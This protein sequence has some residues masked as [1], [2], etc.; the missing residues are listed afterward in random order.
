M[1]CLLVFFCFSSSILFSQSFDPND[2]VGTWQNEK[3]SSHIEMWEWFG[4]TL[5]GSALEIKRSKKE[6]WETLKIYSENKKLIYVAD[7]S[8]NASAIAFKEGKSSK[9]EIL[10]SNFKHDFP[11]H[12]H[13]VFL[14]PNQMKVEVYDT[15]RKKILSFNFKRIPSLE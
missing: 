1:K 12:I 3:D 10:F 11:N 2:L 6:V 4:D 13:Y 9:G 7:V 15:D 8:G 5:A 14:N